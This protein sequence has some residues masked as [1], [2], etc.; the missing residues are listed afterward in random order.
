M[1]KKCR[2]K[3]HA[4][5]RFLLIVALISLYLAYTVFTYG[6]EEGIEI[7]GLTWAFF[8]FLTP[9]PIAGLAFELPIRIITNHK[10]IFTQLVVW[11]FGGLMVLSALLLSPNIFQSTSVLK[12]F[13]H[14]I[15][16]PIPYWTLF[17]LCAMGTFLSAHVADELID[18]VESELHHHYRKHTPHTMLVLFLFFLLCIITAYNAAAGELGLSA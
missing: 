3:E 15:T 18:R 8:I 16:N 6:L 9:V 12:L 2:H 13:Y 1:K 11:S 7:T 10:M 4:I 17:L 5:D 14:V